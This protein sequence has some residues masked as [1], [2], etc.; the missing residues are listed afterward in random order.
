MLDFRDAEIVAE[1]CE[2]RKTSP[3]VLKG[4]RKHTAHHN[5]VPVDDDFRWEM[6]QL[7]VHMCNTIW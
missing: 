5:K 7:H 4:V 2:T 6:G 3:I 1:F